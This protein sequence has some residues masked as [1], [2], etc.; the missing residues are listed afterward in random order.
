MC[1]I[2]EGKIVRCHNCSE[3][4]FRTMLVAVWS[5][6]PLHPKDL[7][8]AHAYPKSWDPGNPYSSSG[9][10]DIDLHRRSTLENLLGRE[11]HQTYRTGPFSSR[12]DTSNN[13]TAQHK[14]K[15]TDADQPHYSA[16][17]GPLNE[18]VQH[19]RQKSYPD[20]Y[21][22]I[23]EQQQH[24]R[25]GPTPGPIPL[26]Q[27]TRI[28]GASQLGRSI[29][30]GA[31]ASSSR[32]TRND[33]AVGHGQ[34][35][36]HREALYSSR[37]RTASDR[38]DEEE[39]Q[40]TSSTISPS[41]SQNEDVDRLTP[42][43]NVLPPPSWGDERVTFFLAQWQLAEERYYQRQRQRLEY[44]WAPYKRERE[45][46]AAVDNPEPEEMWEPEFEEVEIL[47]RDIPLMEEIWA[48]SVLAGEDW[49]RQILDM[50]ETWPPESLAEPNFWTREEGGMMSPTVLR[51]YF[52]ILTLLAE[53]EGE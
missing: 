25:Q 2:W 32:D 45:V 33:G 23:E 17:D 19:K 8:M 21:S 53:L 14:R 5:L 30:S 20:P 12:T 13:G 36:I 40:V 3:T 35:E 50:D 27:A 11:Q 4:E 10:V 52:N 39:H 6:E 37:Q 18:T 15:K 28:H 9:D 46:L 7:K 24:G 51:K 48:H 31:H 47:E 42:G 43:M 16:H 22:A 29:Q 34:Q 49:M 38:I 1:F 26:R 41:P 44:I